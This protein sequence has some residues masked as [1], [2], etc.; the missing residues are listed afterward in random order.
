M[1]ADKLRGT[2]ATTLPALQTILEDATLPDWIVA[3]EMNFDD[4]CRGKYAEEY[5]TCS[6][7]W[8]TDGT[9]N[10][11]RAP[12]DPKGV[13]LAAIKEHLAA[14][15]QIKYVWLDWICMWQGDKEGQRDITV[16]EKAEF[17]HML[18]EVNM[19][20]LGCQVLV[21]L[22]LSY[23]SR[24]WTMY[25]AWLSRLQP[26]AQGLK[27]AQGEAAAR[28]HILPILGASEGYKEAL[29]R[30]PRFGLRAT[31]GRS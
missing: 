25:E 2:V 1:R 8:L 5:L 30:C 12:P 19:L 9:T 22:D 28:C 6:H 27:L 4:A 23:L 16:D 29:S 17:D 14:R 31:R 24:F 20:Y 13:Q 10:P 7:R 21:L 3:K 11:R 18:G 26:M 15:P